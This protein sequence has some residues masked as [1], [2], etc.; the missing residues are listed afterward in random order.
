MSAGGFSFR[1]IFLTDDSASTPVRSSSEIDA[2]LNDALH[3]SASTSGTAAPATTPVSASVADADLVL[4]EGVELAAIYAAAAVPDT[5]YPIEKL[6]KVLEGLNQLDSATK[7][8]AIA[9]MDA[10]DDTWNIDAVV[11]DGKTKRDALTAYQGQVTA[12]EASLSAE[13][14]RRL[15]ANQTDK[16]TRLADIDAQIA[17][18]NTQREQAIAET[19]QV[20]ADLRAKGVSVAEAAERERTRIANAIRGVDGLVALFAAPSLPS[21]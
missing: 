21:A 1:R 18:L 19:A 6:A 5:A 10:A 11:A 20:A 8:T 17:A 9:A 13:I 15:D 12:A 14:S 2:L 7:K 3:P 16:A 4:A